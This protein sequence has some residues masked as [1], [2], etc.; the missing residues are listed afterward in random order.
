MSSTPK[1]TVLGTAAWSLAVLLAMGIL[2]ALLIVPSLRYGNHQALGYG[3]RVPEAPR[4]LTEFPSVKG[5]Q[6]PGLDL[7]LALAGDPALAGRA[8]EIYTTI[9][10]AC[11]GVSGKGDAPAGLALGARD[12]SLA[13]GWKVGPR[14][15]DIYRTL[16][17]GLLPL[18][19]AYD[20][21]SPAERFALAHLVA[22]F[23]A[24]DHG[25][26]SAEEIAALD[27]EYRLSQGVQEPNQVAVPVALAAMA[28]E[29][30]E[31]RLDLRRLAPTQAALVGD[32]VRAART[33]AGLQGDLD[34]VQRARVLASGAPHN[35]FRVA[36]ATLDPES[37][38]RLD[39][40]LQE[41]L[42]L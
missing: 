11:H 30:G 29:V 24:F 19:P 20:T 2:F 3:Y 38:N 40:A 41:A 4:D 23:G 16:T 14:P 8:Q 33:L 26:T 5:Q 34:P 9:C 28:A 10:A 6:A 17:V 35:G 7:E 36:L 31:P 27:A 12:F 22:G 18:M 21:Y 25:R 15:I 42:H 13:D 1:P 37:W 32:A 39:A